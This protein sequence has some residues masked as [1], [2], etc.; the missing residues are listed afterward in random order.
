[1]ER[2]VIDAFVYYCAFGVFH[3]F[4]P[5]L[6]V[7]GLL[8]ILEN[9]II[10]SSIINDTISTMTFRRDDRKQEF[11]QLPNRVITQFI[12]FLTAFTVSN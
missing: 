1:M 10:M 2:N 12:M 7:L 5:Y 4:R 6:F 8:F 9:K 3:E 11:R